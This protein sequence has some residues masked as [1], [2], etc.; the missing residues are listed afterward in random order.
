MEHFYSEAVFESIGDLFQPTLK[1]VRGLVDQL[2]EVRD[3]RLAAMDRRR[4][5]LQIVSH[6]FTPGEPNTF[7]VSYFPIRNAG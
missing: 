3:R 4:I 2:R 7:G 1:A 5:A 6:A